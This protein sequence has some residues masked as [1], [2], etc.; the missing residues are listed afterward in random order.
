MEEWQKMISVNVWGSLV[1][2]RLVLQEMISRGSGHI[3]FMS[4]RAG[5]E[6]AASLAV[7]SGTKHMVEGIVGSLRQELSGTGVKLSVVRPSGVDTPGYQHAMAPTTSRGGAGATTSSTESP[8]WVSSSP[9]R[10]LSAESV[11]KTV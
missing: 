6:P 4:S 8:G 11:A 10:C 7:H 1:M 2:T 9:S 5:V 3:L